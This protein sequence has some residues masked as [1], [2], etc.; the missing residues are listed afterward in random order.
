MVKETG[1]TVDDKV[2]ETGSTHIQR[3]RKK[4]VSVIDSNCHIWKNSVVDV[5]RETYNFN[6]GVTLQ[7]CRKE[8]PEHSMKF[9]VQIPVSSWNNESFT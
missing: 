2:F 8:G 7:N 5:N 1:E 4:Q 3:N 6:I 9:N